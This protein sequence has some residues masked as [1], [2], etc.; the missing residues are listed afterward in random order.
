MTRENISTERLQAK[1]YRAPEG[2][3]LNHMVEA[4]MRGDTLVRI[5]NPKDLTVTINAYADMGDSV[6]SATVQRHFTAKELT[7]GDERRR[8]AY[9]VARLGSTTTRNAFRAP[10]RS[11]C[12]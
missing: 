9:E 11:E 3:T 5:R 4:T 10:V 8:R 7:E 1:G 2:L 12:E 6:P